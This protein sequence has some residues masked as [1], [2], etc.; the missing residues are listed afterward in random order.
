MIGGISH[1]A[2]EIPQSSRQV[3]EWTRLVG[4]GGGV[5]GKFVSGSP[6]SFGDPAQRVERGR[7]PGQTE[8]GDFAAGWEGV[9]LFCVQSGVRRAFAHIVRDLWAMVM[10][11]R[12]FRRKRKDVIS[13]QPGSSTFSGVEA[14]PQ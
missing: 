10:G 11:V 8:G 4:G 5:R 6:I 3:G 2:M 12:C 14:V 1:L 13:A 7:K 9:G